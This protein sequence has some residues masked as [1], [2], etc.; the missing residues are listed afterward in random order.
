MNEALKVFTHIIDTQ[1]YSQS[2]DIINEKLDEIDDIIDQVDMAQIFVK[3]SGLTCM[4]SLLETTELDYNCRCRVATV[5]GTLSQN[6]ISVQDL[7]YTQN[8][9]DRLCKVYL[10]CSSAECK[11]RTKVGFIYLLVLNAPQLLEV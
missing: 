5:I 3:Y 9:V 7:Y 6:I 4:L 11:L 1:A 2:T 8:V 10:S